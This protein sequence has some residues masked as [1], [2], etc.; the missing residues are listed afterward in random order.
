M[1]QLLMLA[2]A[3]EEDSRRVPRN[4]F[5]TSRCNAFDLSEEDFINN[6]RLNKTLAFQLIEE[7][8]PFL[9][10]KTIRKT[11]LSTEIKVCDINMRILNVV[12]RFP[13]CTEDEFIWM[14]CNL[15]R[16]FDSGSKLHGDG[17]LLGDSAYPQELHLHTPYSTVS[18][19]S[20]EEEYNIAHSRGKCVVERCNGVLKNR[21]RCLLKHRTL[22]YMPEAACRIINSCVILHNLC[23]GGEMKWEDFDL[24]AEDKLFNTV[25]D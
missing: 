1:A 19:G 4:R 6:F 3:Q 11:A 23:I 12:A 7:L 14:S 10:P 2:I 8:K 22:H 21:F 13:G 15:K 5:T 25:F 20:V 16:V 24:P 9:E 17:W 18:T